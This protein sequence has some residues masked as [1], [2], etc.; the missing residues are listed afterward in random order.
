MAFRRP[1]QEA[2]WLRAAVGAAVGAAV[3]RD[4]VLLIRDFATESERKR[5]RK[6]MGI[7]PTKR[8]FR[9]FTSFED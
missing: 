4:A 6:R 1:R 7:E 8:L 5:K 3:A 9:R 2:A